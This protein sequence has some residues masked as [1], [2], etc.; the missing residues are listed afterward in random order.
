MAK[1]SASSSVLLTSN[2][3]HLLVNKILTSRKYR[4]LEIPVETVENL[5]AIANKGS[6]NL[7]DVEAIVRQKLH[8]ITALYLGD[9]D[10]FDAT[11]ELEEFIAQD[12][13]GNLE[14]FCLKHLASHA[15]TRERIPNQ[16]QFYELLFSHTGKPDSILDLA[17]GLN[18]LSI[19]WMELPWSTSYYAYDLNSPRVNFLNKF[20]SALHRQPLA[21]KQ[22]ILVTPPQVK[23]DVAFFFKEAHRFEERERGCNRKFWQALQV[24]H[25]LVSLPTENLNGNHSLL[26]QQR[27]LVAK[28]V[29]GLNWHVTELLFPKEIVL[30]IEKDQ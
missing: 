21:F 29:N 23:A 3:I 25:L 6:S 16:S 5:I 20:F 13:P 4:G 28:T 18:P 14:R 19:P 26:D 1:N 2:E 9:P 8:G 24:R 22:D 11:R 10:Y 12:E 15:S 30:C 27:R 7:R 17:C